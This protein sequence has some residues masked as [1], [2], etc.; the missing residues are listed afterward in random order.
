MPAQI[1]FFVEEIHFILKQKTVLRNWISQTIIT[2]KHTLKEVNFIFCSDE[3]L[4][5]INQGY[6]NHDTYTDIITF[7]NS[8]N[9]QDIVG[10]IFISVERVTE[11]AGIYQTSVQNELRRVMIHGVL[12]L[13]GYPDKAPKDK[14]LMTA[15]ENFYLEQLAATN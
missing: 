9:E 15:K 10:D 2:E 8:E 11:N 3:Y 6:L 7:D 12:H 14:Q 1:S 4:L 13:L 5:K